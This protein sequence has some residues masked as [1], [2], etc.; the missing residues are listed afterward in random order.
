MIGVLEASNPLYPDKDKAIFGPSY[1]L[2]SGQTLGPEG[3]YHSRSKS[4]ASFKSVL[5]PYR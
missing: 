3:L 5:A 4:R 1:P 2:K